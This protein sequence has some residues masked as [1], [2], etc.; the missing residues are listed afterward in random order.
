[1]GELELS[2]PF[3][4]P[5]GK[6]S[7]IAWIKSLVDQGEVSTIIDVGAGSGTYLKLLQQHR[8]KVPRIVAIEVWE[9]YVERFNLR[10]RYDEVVMADIGELFLWPMG[11]LAI[12]GDVLEH[13]PMDVAGEVWKRAMEEYRFIVAAIPLRWQQKAINSN[14]YEEH[15]SVWRMRDVRALKLTSLDCFPSSS[16]TIYKAE[17][18]A[19]ILWSKNDERSVGPG[20]DPRSDVSTGMGT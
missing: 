3:S 5:A 15:R 16:A 9:P 20:E 4:H 18:I 6:P 11:D 19:I 1:V 7:T 13:L 10:E 17:R 8:V 2:M 12:F 14:P